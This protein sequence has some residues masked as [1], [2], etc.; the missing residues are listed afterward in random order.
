M[1][2]SP[3]ANVA[4][5]LACVAQ[6]R[7]TADMMKSVGTQTTMHP[8]RK[9]A[10]ASVTRA[11]SVR[12][13]RKTMQRSISQMGPAGVS[14]DQ[15]AFQSTQPLSKTRHH[16]ESRSSTGPVK[17]VRCHRQAPRRRGARSGSR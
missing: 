14:D 3:S 11:T 13:T 4:T 8:Q 2:P 9:A 5:D 16:A 1:T 10:R 17:H 12:A 6:V 7:P 15:H